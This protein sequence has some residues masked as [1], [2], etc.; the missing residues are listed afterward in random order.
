[1]ITPKNTTFRLLNIKKYKAAQLLAKKLKRKA[2]LQTIGFGAGAVAAGVAGY[3]LVA[4]G[5]KGNNT[6]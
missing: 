1:M 4:R 6:K 5:R 3:A 2:I